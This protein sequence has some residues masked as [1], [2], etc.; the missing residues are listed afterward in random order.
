MAREGDGA[1]I[2]RDRIGVERE[3][4]AL[5]EQSAERRSEQEQADVALRSGW[6]GLDDDLAAVADQE[7]ADVGNAKQ[8]PVRAGRIARGFVAGGGDRAVKYLDRRHRTVLG[9]GQLPERHGR[10]KAET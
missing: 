3:Q 6:R 2:H 5:V 1:P 7:A 4:A 10:A 9:K 8:G